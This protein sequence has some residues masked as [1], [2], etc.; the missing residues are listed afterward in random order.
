MM[1]SPPDKV[2]VA[3]DWTWADYEPHVE[4]LLNAELTADTLDAW[5]RQWSDF[6]KLSMEVVS[7]LRV[8][9]T[10][11]TTDEEADARYRRFMSEVFP[12]L[13]Q[14]DFKIK[15]KLV[16]SGLEPANSAVPMRQVK[17]DI[18]L[19]REENLPLFTQESD[20]GLAYNRI[21]GAQT[22][23][24]DGEERTIA[25]M[26]PVFQDPERGTRKNAWMLIAERQKQDREQL[27]D[28]W[29]QFMDLRKQIAANA[30]FENYRDF[31]WLSKGRFDYTP[32]DALR[33]TDAIAQV[34]VPAA[35]RIYERR[36]QQLGVDRLR[37]WDLDVDPQGRTPLRPF[38]DIEDFKAK[39][40]TIFKQVDP[41]LGEQFAIMRAEGLLDLDNR[42][43]K[44]PGGYCTGFPVSERPFIFQNAVGLDR[45]IRTLL[46]EAGH[47]F[48]GFARFDLPYAMQASS[49][50]EFNEVA[51][52]AME[53]LAM[54]YIGGDNG[55][56]YYDQSDAAR[57][58]T[59]HLRKIILFW[60]YMAV[61][62]E[63]QHW[64]YNNHGTATDPANC[65]AKWI[66]LWERF[67]P[68][69]D[70]YNLEEFLP[71]RWRQQLHIFRYPFYYVEYG[72][73]QLGAVQV[74][75]NA[76]KDQGAALAKYREALTLGGTVTLPELFA[77]SG[78]KLA[79]DVDTLGQAVD[80][81][82]GTINELEPA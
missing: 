8:A 21:I 63:F 19:F 41:Q 28:L 17:A 48:H 66:E 16:N 9:T 35:S 59:E 55:D 73:A 5:M 11:D 2:V 77:A 54:P 71:N 31:V 23:E 67:M 78:V 26:G 18:D 69:V 12:K 25:Q 72:L 42:K 4:A 75:A 22:V 1:K 20:L 57:S 50:M 45:D 62:V 56:V 47:A 74:W 64:I 29:R 34:V 49:P 44:G 30:G 13:R 43:G 52:M 38:A 27:N 76:L 33:F 14:A 39:A 15:Q 24:W 37:P 81:L 46:H 32:E 60:P 70:F 68:G 7:R 10:V 79:F 3:M 65:D 53:L 61:V 82:E 80:L 58:R 40:E 51:S 36:R 6:S